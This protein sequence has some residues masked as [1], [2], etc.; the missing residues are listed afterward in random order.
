M[1]I[2]YGISAE[3]QI[4]RLFPDYK[5]AIEL[6]F[7]LKHPDFKELVVDYLF[8]KR[9]FDRFVKLNE[10]EGET[11]YKVLLEELEMDLMEYLESE[12]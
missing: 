3:T 4:I 6:L 7:K 11:H 2:S 9:E 1:G 12:I 8:C 5:D 10:S